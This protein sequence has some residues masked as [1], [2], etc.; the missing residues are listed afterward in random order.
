MT[1]PILLDTCALIWISQDDAISPDARAGLDRL[2]AAGGAPLI[3][4]ITAWEIGL[5]VSRGRL[6]LTMSPQRWWGL[7]LSRLGLDLAPMS[8]GLLIASSE[9]PG[10]PPNDPADRIIAATARE[11][12]VRLMTRDRK[13]L[14]YAEAGH[15][16]VLAC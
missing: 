5:L 13:L 11:Q 4:P 10:R 1:T 3:S 16:D 15:L 12:G 6:A 14:T 9:L 8:P 2:W 7:A